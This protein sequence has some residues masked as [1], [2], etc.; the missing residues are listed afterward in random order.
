MVT[1]LEIAMSL[2]EREA[3][4]QRLAEQRGKRPVYIRAIQWGGQGQKGYTLVLGE[5]FMGEKVLYIG[6]MTPKEFYTGSNHAEILRSRFAPECPI[7]E[8][9]DGL[10]L[11]KTAADLAAYERMNERLNE[12]KTVYA[13]IKITKKLMDISG[14]KGPKS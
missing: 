14:Y 12:T 13:F 1:T 5:R 6:M 2:N 8:R 10:W 11:F 7:V 9:H 3:E 4:R